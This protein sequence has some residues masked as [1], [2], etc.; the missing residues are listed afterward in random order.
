MMR[1]EPWTFSFADL[2]TMAGV[3]RMKQ[4]AAEEFAAFVG[5]LGEN[6]VGNQGGKSLR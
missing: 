2:Y 3:G 4:Q 6:G 5:E 1:V